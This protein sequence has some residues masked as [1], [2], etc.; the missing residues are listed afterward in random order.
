MKKTLDNLIF[1]N[2]KLL[3][4]KS[5][6]VYDR[7]DRD[8]FIQDDSQISSA[9]TDTSE[10]FSSYNLIEV[11]LNSNYMYTD[12]RNDLLNNKKIDELSSYLNLPN[13]IDKMFLTLEN[14]NSKKSYL[15]LDV[16]FNNF[17]SYY[18]L[19][20]NRDKIG[21]S[22]KTKRVC[23][24]DNFLNHY[25]V[26]NQKSSFYSKKDDDVFSNYNLVFEEDSG[27]INH[28]RELN[29]GKF[30]GEYSVYN[31][32]FTDQNQNVLERDFPERF[33]GFYVVKY[34]RLSLLNTEPEY[35]KIATKFIKV[36]YPVQNNKK[37]IK[38]R[39]VKYDSVYKYYIYPVYSLS[40]FSYDD[41][42]LQDQILVCGYPLITEDIHAIETKNPDEPV[43]PFAKV[44][45][46]T[47]NLS[48]SWEKP[49][50]SQEDIKGFKVFKRYSLDEPFV[51]IKEYRSHLNTDAFV[52]I[53]NVQGE[54]IY[55]TPGILE[56]SCID[57]DFN[58]DKVNI[59]SVCS[60]DAHGLVSNYSTQIGVVY[61]ILLDET[62]I[63]TISISGAPLDYPNM[64]IKR[65]TKYFDNEDS[66]ISN[67]PVC[68]KKNKFS[69][70]FTPDS[71]SVVSETFEVQSDEN[72]VEH[73]FENE[74]QYHVDIFR[75]NGQKNLV[76]NEE[77]PIIKINIS[78]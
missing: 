29:T 2:K 14:L 23:I 11:T 46:D 8:E 1:T 43:G 12:N 41:N 62:S 19:V 52:D 45:K 10:S 24:K 68:N 38:D 67:T 76:I 59:Y 71:L 32:R 69:L 25:K 49:A 33:I 36:N 60:V 27:F 17:I 37:I 50:E 6:Y 15:T 57:E 42:I 44:L 75:L 65:N 58:T 16:D 35:N 18:E 78:Q 63:D 61:D 64:F 53:H 56:L 28:D 55:S 70:Y 74:T 39:F 22:N 51:L 66:I 7:Y 3:E 20:E 9:L 34:K 5:S 40:L 47:L 26:S 21:Y 54:N 4:L 30:L 77:M 31:R 72:Q 73:L 13:N 48:L